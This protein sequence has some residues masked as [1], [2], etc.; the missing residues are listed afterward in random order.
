MTSY[1]QL[2]IETPNPLYGLKKYPSAVEFME[3]QQNV[4]WFSQEIRV[5]NDKQDFLV[6]MSAEQLELAK[7][8]TMI[9]VEMEQNVGDIWGE[10]AKWFPHFEIE[11]AA[12]QM[13][14]L[15]KCVHAPFYQQLSDVLL[16]DP[17]ETA[18]V[19][20]EVSA[21]KDKLVL[22][23]R[24][25]KNSS[26]NKLL[27]LGVLAMIEQVLL[28]SNFAML[29][30]FQAN[31][32]NYAVNTMQG[33]DFVI[34]DEI[35]HGEFAAYLFNTLLEETLASDSIYDVKALHKELFRV[36]EEILTHEDEVSSYIFA[37]EDTTINAINRRHLKGFTRERMNF[38]LELLGIE[39][40]FRYADNPISKWF[41]NEANGVSITD[42]FARGVSDYT[43]DWSEEGFSRLPYLKKEEYK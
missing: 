8:D 38:V 21:I 32:Y 43:R 36:A 20:E 7:I 14:S 28:F 26:E 22:I 37:T 10:I 17:A 16:I 27:T 34:R 11:A 6:T 9:F 19:K 41:F 24:I 5:D 25:V 39:K 31:G 3:A 2:P 12:L 33:L 30:S 1:K 4:L 42:F 29:K 13:Q 18:R 35:L 15:E 23:K 40:R